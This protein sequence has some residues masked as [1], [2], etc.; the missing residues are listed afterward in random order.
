MIQSLALLI[1]LLLLMTPLRA[2]NT[3]NDLLRG[4]NAM[5]KGS[6]G[7]KQSDEEMAFSLFWT[8]YISGFTDSH[9]IMLM[10]KK[11]TIYCYPPQGIENGQ[12]A[13][14]VAKYLRESPKELHQSARLC[15]LLALR[16][17]FP[18]SE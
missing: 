1:A 17:A 2:D 8:G 15:L 13:R 4:C 9:S 6:D 14:I 11:A 10:G 3:G 5:I 7:V 18:C 16:N 12:V